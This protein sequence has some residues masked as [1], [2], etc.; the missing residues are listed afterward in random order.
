MIGKH[1]FQRGK[2]QMAVIQAVV[3]KLTSTAV[4]NNYTDIMKSMEDCFQTSLTDADLKELIRQQLENPVSWKISSMDVTG[5]GARKTTYSMPSRSSSVVI[6]NMDSVE[7][8]KT[9][10]QRVL[11]GN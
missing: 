5:T 10:I 8:A 2:N 7:Q 9:E 6:P 4:L 11:A 3:Q 1:D